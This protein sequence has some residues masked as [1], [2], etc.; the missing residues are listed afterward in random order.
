VRLGF[1]PGDRHADRFADRL[2][3][4]RADRTP[5][6]AAFVITFAIGAIGAGFAAVLVM[7]GLPRRPRHTMTALRAEDDICPELSHHV[8]AQV[9]ADGVG[10]R[11]R[12]RQVVT[13]H[14]GLK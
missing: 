5:F 11:T 8:V 6:E 10:V 13:N 14:P 12:L 1:E 7:F 4:L 9:V 2:H 3:C